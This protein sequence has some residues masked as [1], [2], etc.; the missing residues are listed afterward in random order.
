MRIDDH[1]TVEARGREDLR[2]QFGF[3]VDRLS[4]RGVTL[5]FEPAV[6]ERLLIAAGNWSSSLNPVL[7]LRKTWHDLVGTPIEEM[8][9]DRRLQTGS[10]LTVGVGVDEATLR[11]AVRSN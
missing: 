4:E 5:E 10:H 1:A 3:A 7:M 8:M 2:R 6:I 9:I 11:F